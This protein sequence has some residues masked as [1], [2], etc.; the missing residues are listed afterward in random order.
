MF[1]GKNSKGSIDKITYVSN[2]IDANKALTKGCIFTAICILV[3]WLGYL[4]KIFD[5]N[6]RI[7]LIVNI[8]FPILIVELCSTY[9]YTK[10]K[11][12][13]KPNFKYFL[14]FQF[15]VAIMILNIFIPKHTLILWAAGL[16]I[17][18]HY[19]DSK[20]SFV[21]FISISIMMLISLYLAL[22]VGEW[23]ANLLNGTREIVVQGLTVKTDET[24]ISQRIEWLKI[25]LENGD[26]RYLKV[27]LYYYFPWE[28]ELGITFFVCYT[29]SNRSYRLLEQADKQA[30]SNATISNELLVA[31]NIQA[32]ALPKEFEKTLSLDA[33]GLMIPA[34]EVGGDFYDYFY[35]DKTHLAFVISDISGKGVPAALF[36]MRTAT[37]IKSLT[38]SLKADTKK[39]LER[40]NELLSENNEESMFSTTWLGILNLLTG[41][42]KYTNAGHN[43]PL[44]IHDG[45]ASFL[46][47][48][49]GVALGA[50]SD[51]KYEEKTI[52]L[53]KGD[54]I[55]LYTDGII[56]T[57][58]KDKEKFGQ[59]ELFEFAVNNKEKAPR[60]F[61][62]K[63]QK[64]VNDFMGDE[65]QKDDNTMLMVEFV[66]EIELV[67]KKLFKASKDELNNLFEYSS[68][69]LRTL[70]FNSKEIIMINTA[71]EEVFVN[72]S[73]Y[74]YEDGG[75]VEIS[76]SNDLTKAVFVFTDEGKKFN[77]LENDDPDISLGSNE[78][79]I[80]G[81]GIFM[82][83]KIMDKVEYEYKD[84]KNILTL[85]KNRK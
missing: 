66:K 35:I 19:Y 85:T 18:N 14:I 47:D 62:I 50:I 10:T 59:D 48:K 15:L 13:E 31:G 29:L 8:V 2:E 80:G 17:V 20:A 79:E 1:E 16:I 54:K 23:D 27:F 36:M 65:V 72:V 25:L 69:L 39:I 37:L 46:N 44:I 11:F 67:E 55:L 70:N 74:A 9:I 24:T 4:V 45:M 40:C 76:L 75:N 38:T 58:N 51:S 32:Q 6:S 84:G 83:K 34:K 49:P 81:L 41:E 42:L 82:V 3:A 71:L 52:K 28:I 60:E 12:I 56:E 21:T 57:T 43:E 77:P 26:N 73:N 7:M 22:F 5:V 30:K 68:T 64:A 63:L 78:R 33:F 61:I 53:D